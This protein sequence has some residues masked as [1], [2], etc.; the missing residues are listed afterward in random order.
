MST[1]SRRKLLIDDFEDLSEP[2][3]LEM[4]TTKTPTKRKPLVSLEDLEE[5]FYRKDNSAQGVD[6]EGERLYSSPDVNSSEAIAMQIEPAGTRSSKSKK[7][8]KPRDKLTVAQVIMLNDVYV[9]EYLPDLAQNGNKRK[10]RRSIRSI[11]EEKNLA[12][13]TVSDYFKRFKNNSN[14]F[15]EYLAS[16]KG[17]QF[18]KARSFKPKYYDLKN[19]QKLVEWILRSR[20][21]G[22]TVIYEDIKKMAPKFLAPTKPLKFASKWI[23][24]FLKRNNLSLRKTTTTLP[25]VSAKDMR[26]KID[27]FLETVKVFRQR[28]NYDDDFIINFD[29]TAV[30]FDFNV[31][32]IEQK[33]KSLVRK[34]KLGS[35]KRKV[36]AVLASTASGK[37]LPTAI[38]YN[39]K[40]I[41]QMATESWENQMEF[42]YTKSGW[43]DTDVMLSYFKKILLPYIK[44]KRTLLIFDSY[45]CHVSKEFEE[46][47]FKHDNIDP[48]L[49]PGGLTFLLQPLDVGTNRIFK[50]CVHN[51]WREFLDSKRE[52]LISLQ[53]VEDIPVSTE[54]MNEENKELSKKITN[55]RLRKLFKQ[56]SFKEARKRRKSSSTNLVT[57]PEITVTSVVRWIDEAISTLKSSKTDR[58]K[59]SFKVCGLSIALD[60]SQDHLVHNYSYL[61]KKLVRLAKEN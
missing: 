11:A 50:S 5:N 36:T 33:G 37:L 58:I 19:E 24:R 9:H 27:T 39:R 48:L 46:E 17:G 2:I 35:E 44:K 40:Q 54:R 1:S 22:L 23:R 6:E 8:K 60:G 15:K 55:S 59:K 42:Y 20:Q 7:K 13:S 56:N 4:E 31:K 12:K 26:G 61:E 38:V 29:E 57:K 16:A 45:R 53:K 10:N 28:F 43:V 25:P 21:A 30:F 51:S 34:L 41:L 18:R 49:I 3:Y 52:Q 47:L 14:F 32:T